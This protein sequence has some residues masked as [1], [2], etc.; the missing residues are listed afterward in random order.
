MTTPAQHASPAASPDRDPLDARLVRTVLEAADIDRALT[1]I[2]HEILERNKGAAELVLLGIP[3]RG[4]AA[5]PPAGRP[6]RRGRA[7]PGPGRL[8]STS[9]CTA[10]TCGCARPARWSAPRSR[11]AGS[12]ARSWSSSTT[13][14]SPAARSGPRWTRSATSA[15]PALVQ[16]AV[17]VDRGHRELPIRADYV[18]KNLPTSLRE[19]VRVLLAEH[20]GRDAV[21][22]EQPDGRRGMK[23][24]LVSAADLTYDD[25]LLVLDT[26]AE[27]AA[28]G[29]RRDQEAAHA[30]RPHGGQPVLRGLHP[31]PD[32]VRG[33]GQAAV[34]GR[35]QLLGQG[36]QRLQGRV[37]QG[38]RADPGGDGRRRRRHPAPRQRR[39][40]PAGATRAGSAAASSTPGTA[41]TST[42]PRRCWT[43]SRCVTTCG[44]RSTSPG[45][46]VTIVGDVLHSRVARSNVL[47]LATARRRGHAG[48]AADAAA[49]RRRDLAVLGVVRPGRPA[50]QVR[51]GDDA[52]GA[53][54]ADGAPRSSRAPTSTAAATGWTRDRAATLP[55]PRD[56]HAPRPDE[57]RHGDRGRGGRRPAVHDR[58]AGRQRRQR[59]DGRALPA[60]RRRRDR[61]GGRGEAA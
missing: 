21:L 59:A 4:V 42:R 18:G 51:R 9:P 30:A 53:A 47:L 61:R 2:A 52:A 13:C 39:A 6:H 8:A 12:T 3:T 49:G 54:R 24:H 44:G 32:L 34:G 16:L 57:P 43:R 40:A 11:P 55:G 58:R 22:L 1:R 5:R 37:A 45:R 7:R 25:A 23:R 27:M 41:P 48:R 29:R 15:G 38:H 14:S 28:L 56:R 36:L 46:R 35:H 20:D 50:A 33:G 19:T 31:H 26:A 60:A 10:T 17:L